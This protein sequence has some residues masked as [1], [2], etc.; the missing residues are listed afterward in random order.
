ME[1]TSST[2]LLRS[3]VITAALAYGAVGFVC[4]FFGPIFLLEDFGCGPL[5]GFLAAPVGAAIGGGMALWANGA[6]RSVVQYRRYVVGVAVVF[7]LAI[8]GLV[9]VQ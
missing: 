7:G 9:L 4:G 3:R 2:N 1:S 8:L 5:T 6:A